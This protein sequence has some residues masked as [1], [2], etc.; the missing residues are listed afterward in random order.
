MRGSAL[1]NPCSNMK[2]HNTP[3]LLGILT[4]LLCSASIAS[5]EEPK[6]EKPPSASVLKKYDINKD[7]K[8]DETEQAAVFADKKA[9]AAKKAKGKANAAMKADTVK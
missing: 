3:A 8:L 5:A 6:T 1:A 9:A 4:L 2:K 7:G